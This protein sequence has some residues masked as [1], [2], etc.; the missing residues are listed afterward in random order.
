V[1]RWRGVPE[2]FDSTRA[3]SART[4]PQAVA[5]TR[6]P[7]ECVPDHASRIHEN[8]DCCRDGDQADRYPNELRKGRWRQRLVEAQGSLL[9]FPAPEAAEGQRRSQA[10][11]REGDNESRC[12]RA[13]PEE[14]GYGKTSDEQCKGRP[15]PG[16]EGSL[17]CETEAGVRLRAHRSKLADAA[18]PPRGRLCWFVCVPRRLRS[19]HVLALP[20]RPGGMRKAPSWVGLDTRPSRA[21]VSRAGGQPPAATTRISQLVKAVRSL[22][23]WARHGHETY[24]PRMERVGLL[25]LRNREHR[26]LGRSRSE[27]YE[28]TVF[29]RTQSSAAESQTRHGGTDRGESPPDVGADHARRRRPRR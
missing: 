26:W 6:G 13:R 28:L 14:F 15:D 4:P 20:V 5:A 21:A 10:D 8:Q 22:S 1:R 7:S 16:K 17:V 23:P 24:D 29:N 18:P 3:P 19:Q 9:F 25:G 11:K 27:G 12:F 2:W